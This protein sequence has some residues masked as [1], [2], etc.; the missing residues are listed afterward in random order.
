MPTGPTHTIFFLRHWHGKDTLVLSGH[1][2]AIWRL[3]LF[4]FSVSVKGNKSSLPF[5]K[6]SSNIKKAPFSKAVQFGISI[7]TRYYYFWAKK[8]VYTPR[9]RMPR[10]CAIQKLDHFRNFP[11][12]IVTL[13]NPYNS[14]LKK[15]IFERASK[16]I[17]KA[18]L[19][20]G[21]ECK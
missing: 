7:I 19:I 20:C 21:Q 3:F 9:I 16:L 6:L 11:T 17:N 8:K 10:F 2:V 12:I 1:D 18:D 15:K 14:N 4:T 5:Y 13:Y